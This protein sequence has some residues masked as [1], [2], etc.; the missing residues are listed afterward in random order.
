MAGSVMLQTPEDLAR[1]LGVDVETIEEHVR[2]GAPVD[3]QGRLNLIQ[4][5]AWML[6]TICRGKDSTANGLD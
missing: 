4:Y 3:E 6:R 5:A 2:H 1:L